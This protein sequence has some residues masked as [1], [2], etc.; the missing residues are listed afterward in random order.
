MNE[1]KKDSNQHPLMAVKYNVMRQYVVLLKKSS[2]EF[3]FLYQI[4]CC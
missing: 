3:F 2:L 1:I 4:L